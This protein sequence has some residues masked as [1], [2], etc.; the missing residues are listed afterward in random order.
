MHQVTTPRPRRFPVLLLQC[1]FLNTIVAKK[2]EITCPFF[3]R[4]RHVGKWTHKSSTFNFLTETVSFLNPMGHIDRGCDALWLPKSYQDLT[5]MPPTSIVY[6]LRYGSITVVETAPQVVIKYGGAFSEEII[7]AR[8][9]HCKTLLPVP[10][11]IHHPPFTRCWC[12]YME[13][14][15]GV[16]LDK[17]IDTLTMEQLSHIASQLKS[18]LAQLHSVE[19]SKMLGALSQRVFP[20]AR[21]PKTRLLKRYRVSRSLPRNVDVI[22]YGTAHRVPAVTNPTKRCHQ[23]HAWRSTSQEYHCGRISHYRDCRLGNWKILSCI[24]GVL[25][26]ARS[27]LYD[28]RVE[29][30]TPGSLCGGASRKGDKCSL[31]TFARRRE[32]SRVIDS[33][34]YGR[35]NLIHSTRPSNCAMNPSLSKVSLRLPIRRSEI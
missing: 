35:N 3:F 27:V 17:V 16:S 4:H 14:I 31:R 20:T 30:G 15:P 32:H 25:P 5:K 21:V 13:K 28:A 11:I 2:G 9:A 29:A 8:F 7:C 33:T 26:D 24:L 19:W 6:K 10:R 23:I 34:L 1:I 22:L 18:I 12:I